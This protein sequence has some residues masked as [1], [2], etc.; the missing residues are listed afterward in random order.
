MQY[1][2]AVAFLSLVARLQSGNEYGEKAVRTAL[3]NIKN[4]CANAAKEGRGKKPNHCA[5]AG[6]KELASMLAENPRSMKDSAPGATE[7]MPCS[8]TAAHRMMHLVEYKS[9]APQ[10]QQAATDLHKEKRMDFCVK[11]LRQIKDGELDLVVTWFLG[12]VLRG[13]EQAWAQLAQAQGLDQGGG[14]APRRGPSSRAPRGRPV[15]QRSS[16]RNGDLQNA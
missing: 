1:G 7:E 5:E 6:L 4:G 12:R 16:D 10:E 13:G 8:Q 9:V 15:C 11:T 2:R 14:E 3:E